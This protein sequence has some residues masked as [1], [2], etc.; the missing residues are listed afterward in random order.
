MFFLVLG[1]VGNCGQVNYSVVKVGVIGVCKVL[2]LELVKCKIIV[3]C[4]VSGLIDIGMINMELIV[5]EEVMCMIF[6]KWMG[7][8]EEVVGLVSYLMLDIVGYVIC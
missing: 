5:L 3:N 6:F 7:E 8:V 1:V 4:I 2:V